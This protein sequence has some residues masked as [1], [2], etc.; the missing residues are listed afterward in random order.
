MRA[1]TPAQDVIVD[2]VT[3]D[4]DPPWVA[5]AD[6][7]G[8]SLQLIDPDQDNNRVSNWS[9]GSGWK[10]FSNTKS[11]G[12]SSLI[13]LFLY[14][15]AAGGDAYLDDISL[16][17]G[18]TPVVGENVLVNGDFESPLGPAWRAGGRASNTVITT[19][20]AHSGAASLHLIIDPGAIVLTNFVQYFS[21]LMAGSNYTISFWYLPG[22]RGT[23][24]SYRVNSLFSGSLNPAPIRFTP[25]APNNAGAPLPPYPPL[26]LSEVQ[27]ENISGL[28]D[29]FG[30]ND[31]WVE[32]Y[33]G[34]ASQLSLDG[35]YLA[36]NY[37]N[38]TQWPFLLLVKIDLY[39]IH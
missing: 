20:V 2:R 24:L 32:M 4:D 30:D 13:N 6:G 34:G 10:F 26:W 9:D 28:A 16:V 8:A 22:S 21:P 12:S 1:A 11:V 35:F 33:N 29:N 37:S 5:A 18:N 36:N 39:K 27:P 7:Q 3:Y 31:P 19:S 25:G 23:N 38:L 14:F 17:I 15:D